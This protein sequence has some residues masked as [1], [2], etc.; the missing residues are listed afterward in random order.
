MIVYLKESISKN[1][2]KYYLNFIKLKDLNKNHKQIKYFNLN[3]N[4]LLENNDFNLI[5]N[6][7][8]FKKIF[9]D[10]TNFISNLSTSNI[11][12]IIENFNLNSENENE[13]DNDNDNENENINYNILKNIIYNIIDLYETN[14]KFKCNKCD[15]NFSNKNNILNHIIINLNDYDKLSCKKCNYKY[16]KNINYDQNIYNLCDNKFCGNIINYYNDFH[17]KY[18]NFYKDS[19]K[20]TNSDLIKLYKNN[21]LLLN[22]D[23]SKYIDTYLFKIY[24]FKF[25]K[26]IKND[27]NEN[28]IK[29]NK[30]IDFKNNKLFS[31]NFYFKIVTNTIDY[32]IYNNYIK[33]IEN[34][35]SKNTE[36]CNICYDNIC[37]E[38]I[39]KCN[40]CNFLVHYNCLKSYILINFHYKENNCKYSCININLKCPY[41]RNFYI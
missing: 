19:Y 20:K 13:N 39:L 9:Y 8:I 23:L 3:E 33:Y 1:F 24:K 27:L 6:I 16:L 32:I 41:C 14:Q 31:N 5:I 11:N 38:C 2:H 36:S 26:F 17:I 22:T 29:E 25:E 21:N 35:D 4:N 30:N 18:I 15:C 34:N 40:K 28:F 12:D 37:D 10:F 7:I